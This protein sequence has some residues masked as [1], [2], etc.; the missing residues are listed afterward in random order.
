MISRFFAAVAAVTILAGAPCASAAP[1]Y[2]L[3]FLPLDFRGAQLNDVGQIVGNASGAAAIYSGGA[4]TF[5]A[6]FA[7]TGE[8]INNLG[9]IVG[10]HSPYIEAFSYI[11]GT[12][13][14]LGPLF[15]PDND[16]SFGTA[17]NDHG[18]V[19]GSIYRG[20]EDT[21]G[22]LLQ[23]GVVT[24]LGTFG[25]DYSPIAALNNHGAATGYAA[26]PGPAGGYHHAYIYQDGT[27]QD[28]GTLDGDI[29]SAGTDINEL[30]QVAGWSGL[31]PFLY[32]GGGMIDLGA[33]GANGGYA[34]ALNDDAVVVGYAYSSLTPGGTG[35]HAFVWAN[36]AM[37][38]LNS[39]VA[40]PGGWELTTAQDINEAGQILGTACQGGSCASVLLTPVPE[41]AAGLMLLAGLAGLG[42]LAP[43]AARRRRPKPRTGSHAQQCMHTS[44]WNASPAALKPSPYD[45]EH[46]FAAACAA[47][48][49]QPDK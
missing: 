19:G 30:G 31:R 28:L 4:V 41:P 21:K 15:T 9:D 43:L 47:A 25:G 7:S 32:S 5:V 18:V 35:T 42:T 40:N 45:A 36:G 10:T 20:G 26:F 29:N 12:L 11:G 23:D 37:T 27:L 22:F 34:T 3:T 46:T 48:C 2:T 49:T 17:I 14:D 38:D 8:G 13:T 6:P 24:E 16:G 39:L 33:L 44:S 1:L